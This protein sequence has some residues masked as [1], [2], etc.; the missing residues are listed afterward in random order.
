VHACT[1]DIVGNWNGNGFIYTSSSFGDSWTKTSAPTGSRQAGAWT[2]ITS[3]STGEVI[4]VGQWGG[5]NGPV[6]VSSDR[7]ITWNRANSG[8]DYY[9]AIT[10]DSTG[11]NI[12]ALS[13]CSYGHA[14]SIYRGSG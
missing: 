14:G 6:W 11:Q 9:S 3:S 2:S 4:A 13:V 12:I 10:S 8:N 7:G 5:G 1:Y